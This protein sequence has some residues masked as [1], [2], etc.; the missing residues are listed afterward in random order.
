MALSA[1]GPGPSPIHQNTGTRPRTPKAMQPE[2][3]TTQLC[4]PEGRHQPQDTLWPGLTHPW[5]SSSLGTSLNHQWADTCPRTTVAPQP[6]MAGPSPPTSR[7]AL[8]L[9]PTGLCPHP[10]AGQHRLWD[11]LSPSA[12][13]IHPQ[14]PV[15]WHKLEDN[16]DPAAMSR[17]GLNH[18]WP[19]IS[20]GTPRPCSQRP[21]DLVL[22]TSGLALAPGPSFTHW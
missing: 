5:A 22:P 16:P 8:A 21:Q 7:L 13:R 19:E 9:E 12:T 11:I 20:S 18:Q 2:T 1:E 15:G 17:T 4:P 6:A 3:P 10:L 14:S